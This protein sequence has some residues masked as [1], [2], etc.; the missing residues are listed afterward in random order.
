MKPNS[1]AV[2]VFGPAQVRI[3]VLLC[4]DWPR[5]IADEVRWTRVLG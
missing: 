2:G 3:R 1:E 4:C 5:W